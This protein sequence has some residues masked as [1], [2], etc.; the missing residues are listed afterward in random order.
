MAPFASAV[1][2][3]VVRRSWSRSERS[4]IAPANPFASGQQLIQ[5]FIHIPKYFEALLGVKR[6]FVWYDRPPNRVRIGQPRARAA[7]PRWP[8]GR[9][10]VDLSPVWDAAHDA[11]QSD[12]E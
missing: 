7:H 8:T 5:N 12:Q 2:A 9:V 3:Y 1:L 10:L 4:P 6:R 11:E